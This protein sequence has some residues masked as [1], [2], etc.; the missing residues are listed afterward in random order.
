MKV[1]SLFVSKVH[2]VCKIYSNSNLIFLAES[3]S[4]QTRSSV[5]VEQCR[6][7][8]FR[9]YIVEVRLKCVHLWIGV[10]SVSIIIRQARVVHPMTSRHFVQVTS[11]PLRALSFHIVILHL[12]H[13]HLV[14]GR[15]SHLVRRVGS[16]AWPL[17]SA[18]MD[19][20][21]GASKNYPRGHCWLAFVSVPVC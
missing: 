18:S 14:I 6:S 9:F 7:A 13:A 1:A 19:R 21:W 12:I 20:T 5:C 15:E 2:D 3:D 8:S 10:D 16:T 17:S 4:Y 11:T